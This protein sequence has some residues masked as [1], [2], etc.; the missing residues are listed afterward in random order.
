VR[1]RSANIVGGKQRRE[2][3]SPPPSEKK[4]EGRLKNLRSSC[5]EVWAKTS[6]IKTRGLGKKERDQL[7]SSLAK[8]EKEGA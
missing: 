3:R 1:E 8:G 6:R 4:E 5:R 2:Q 7:A